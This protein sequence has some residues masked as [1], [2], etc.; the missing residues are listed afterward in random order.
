MSQERRER[1]ADNPW[2]IGVDIGG[3]KIE[4]AC[5][6][7]FGRI[8]SKRK[9][10]THVEM[11]YQAIVAALAEVVK[12]LSEEC[13]APPL[14][15]GVGVAGQVTA[16][17][18]EVSFAPNLKWRNVSF[19]ADLEKA[20]RLQVFI[21]NDVRAA[22][23][24]EWRHGAGAGHK[25]LVCLFIGTGI[26]GGVVSGGQLL[27]GKNNCAGELGH[28]T[29]DLNG[30]EC[31]CGNRGCLEALA[32]GWAL[33]REAKRAVAGFPEQSKMLLE[34]AGGNPETLAAYHLVQAALKDDPLSMMI[35]EKAVEALVSG[36]VGIVNALNP[37]RLILGGGLGGS[38][39]N[40][41][42]RV[43]GGLMRRVL[44]AAKEG[45]DVVPSHLLNDAGVIG[46]ASYALNNCRVNR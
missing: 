44:D 6:D 19:Q 31:T 7:S 21:L 28:M 45:F 1:V 18:G 42:E 12:E 24:G 17:K 32:S 43:R 13:S 14:A 38:I 4:V 41:A 29:I 33:A 27:S 40:L 23:W 25:D 2:A 15:M 8:L 37:S 34:M 20:L 36:C 3:T 30:P 46:A 22:T 10:P 26:G 9:Y 16:Q 11:G 35:I 39:Y 5:I